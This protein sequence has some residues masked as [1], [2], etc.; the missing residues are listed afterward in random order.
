ML[1][2][3]SVRADRATATSRCL[4]PETAPAPFWFLRLVEK[5]RRSRSQCAARRWTS[6][7]SSERLGQ[8]HL[9]P[10][11][12]RDC[13]GCGSDRSLILYV[14]FSAYD[15]PPNGCP[16]RSPYR[17]LPTFQSPLAPHLHVQSRL[18]HSTLIKYTHSG[19]MLH[20]PAVSRPRGELS[21]GLK[22]GA[23]GGRLRTGF[24]AQAS[25]AL[26]MPSKRV[27]GSGAL[28]AHSGISRRE[29]TA[30]RTYARPA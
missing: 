14:R 23:Y 21:S 10:Q 15:K 27:A 6:R 30:R 16:P 28:C 18:A 7:S 1:A 13:A 2:A 9:C 22:W 26:G 20:V 4:L 25:I 5:R 19:T 24:T 3:R 17:G 11:I 12:L 8:P 29:G